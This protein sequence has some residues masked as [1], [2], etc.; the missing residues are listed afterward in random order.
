M[1]AQEKSEKQYCPATANHASVSSHKIVYA[2]KPLSRIPL[3]AA[4]IACYT[5]WT[6][7]RHLQASSCL[8]VFI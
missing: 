1:T 8:L 7:L 5:N 6:I 3:H 2:Q 4:D